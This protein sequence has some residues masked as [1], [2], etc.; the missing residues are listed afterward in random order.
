[1]ALSG[2]LIDMTGKPNAIP[3][4]KVGS[5][6]DFFRTEPAKIHVPAILDD[7]DLKSESIATL[8]AFMDVSA[9]DA[10]AMARWTASS[11]CKHQP[12]ILCT[13]TFNNLEEP[14]MHIEPFNNNP[15]IDHD[16][17]MAM[18]RV[19]FNNNAYEEDI[20]ALL[21][22]CMIVLFGNRFVYVRRP[23]ADKINVKVV[24]YPNTDKDLL[25]AECKPRFGMYKQGDDM[26]APPEDFRWSTTFVRKCLRG[27]KMEG[28]K[29][30]A[31]SLCPLTGSLTPELNVKPS[32][33]NI[34]P[35]LEGEQHL[36]T[37]FTP[38]RPGSSSDGMPQQG[39]LRV[40][41]KMPAPVPPS[42]ATAVPPPPTSQ[43]SQPRRAFK[44]SFSQMASQ[45]IDISSPAK[46]SSG[47][48]KAGDEVE[49][50]LPRAVDETGESVLERELEQMLDEAPTFPTVDLD[51]DNIG[52]D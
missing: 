33:M 9:E 29:T 52:S 35:D 40:E 7:S 20:A 45:E 36:P 1:M 46:S 23:T 44:R 26:T 37:L 41:P 10:K 32:F 30:T 8:K 49:D 5:H 2:N 42:S 18:I 14:D 43:S 13:N 25:T 11:F 3:S 19:A 38:G 28:F 31:P 47:T 6:I 21:K 27:E 12:R 4:F 34:N 51:Q 22:R 15:T 24:K 39:M 48:K 17:F 50:M 16:R